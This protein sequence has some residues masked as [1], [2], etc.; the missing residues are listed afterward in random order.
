MG[1]FHPRGR[2]GRESN[3]TRGLL[4]LVHASHEVSSLA[5]MRFSPLPFVV[6]ALLLLGC[7]EDEA[8]AEVPTDAAITEE[9]AVDASEPEDTAQIEDAPKS[10]DIA[11]AEDIIAGDDIPDVDDPPPHDVG[12]EDSESPTDGEA[13]EDVDPDPADEASAPDEGEEDDAA[14]TTGPQA[15]S[16]VTEDGLTLAALFHVHPS[17]PEKAPGVLLVHQYLQDKSQWDPVVDSLTAEGW[18]VL[19]V[20]L[21]GHGDS[22]PTEGPLNDILHDPL[23][24]PMDIEVALWW[25]Q[26]DGKA[27]PARLAIVG[28]SIGANLACVASAL[29]YG[30]KLH[31]ALSPRDVP[32]GNLAGNPAELSFNGLYCVAGALDN[33]GV[34]ANT[35]TQF[36]TD[37][38]EPKKVVVI[39]GT[40][41]H[42]VAIVNDFPDEWAAIVAWLAE[43]L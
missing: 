8:P 30:T 32:V 26:T 34:Q 22:D 1:P 17:T 21:R 27:D 7:P 38:S 19:A 10:E 9:T 24:A 39:E 20:D 6:F 3:G 25:L 43:H 18:R 31:V 15:V 41:A 36:V 35:C 28:T 42:G 5:M 29:S 12:A 4:F 37:A 2:R 14:P 11:Q 16:F 33:G 23:Q 13:P 40:G